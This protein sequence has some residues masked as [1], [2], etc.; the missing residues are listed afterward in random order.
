MLEWRQFSLVILFFSVCLT[1][2]IYS[3]QANIDDEFAKNKIATK[4]KNKEQESYFKIIS[5]YLVK[6]AQNQL[7]LNSNELIIDNVSKRSSF[8]N[9]LGFFFTQQRD[10]VFFE[11]LLGLYRPDDTTFI[12]KD[13]AKLRTGESILTSDQASYVMNKE[14]FISEGNVHTETKDL[15]SGD[16]IFIESSLVHA[17]PNKQ[18]SDYEKGV[19]GLIKRKRPYEPDVNFSS[20]SIYLDLAINHIRLEGDVYIKRQDVE[21]TSRRG[22]IYLDNQN[23]KLK[24]Y[25]LFDDVKVLEKIKIS[26][27]QLIERKAFGEKLEGITS[28]DKLIL[29]GSP[30]VLQEEDIVKG[31][32]ITLRENNEV[33]EVEDAS[34]NFTIKNQN[35]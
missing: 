14:F 25:T 27:N 28:E 5:Y 35:P 31:N 22:E 6:S 19:K 12:L 32:K 30:K 26:E 20:Q 9:P 34:S 33:I 15:K 8:N 2:I 11:A 29:T 21:A 3:R 13:K 23:K 16:K 1:V 4:G 10:Q 18:K 24:Y 7:Y 17:W